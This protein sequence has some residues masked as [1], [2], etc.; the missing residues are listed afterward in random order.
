MKPLKLTLSAFGPYADET[1][2]DFTQLGGQGLFLVTGDTG[3]GKTTIF[4]GI[5][6]ALYG[7]T[8]GGVREASMLR[9][10]YAKPETPTYAEYIFEYKDAVYTVKRSPDYGR[11]KTRGTGMTTQKGEALLT[12]SDGRAPVTKLKE[13]NQTVTDL[14]GLDMKQFTQ[15]A[16]I[17]Q[18]DFRKLLLAD[19]EE[20]SNIFRKLFHT[21]IY[22][23]IQEKLKFEAGGLDKAYKELLRSIR[24][25]TEQVRYSTEDQLGQQWILMEKNGFEG[26][27]EEG[28]E[29]LEQFLKVDKETLKNLNKQIKE[30]DKELEKVN[31][32]LGKAHKEADAKAR[33]EQLLQ[34]KEVLLPQLE[35]AQK[36]AE[37]GAKEP[38]EIQRLMLSIQKEKENLERYTNLENLLRET[39]KASL[40]IEKLGTDGTELQ[41]R[42]KEMNAVLEEKQKEYQTTDGT[43]K[44]KAETDFRKEKIDTLY[45]GIYK[46]CGNLE[47]LQTKISELKIQSGQE[48]QLAYQKKQDEAAE[49]RRRRSCMERPKID[50]VPKGLYI[51]LEEAYVKYFQQ[52]VTFFPDDKDDFMYMLRLLERWEKKSIPAVLA[53]GRP[54][55]AYA[56]AIGLCEHLPLLIFRDDIRDY[57]NEYKL[58]IGKL[59]YASFAAL[60]DS[61]AAWN[62][63]EKR[64]EIFTYIFTHLSRFDDFKRV[65]NNIQMLAPSKKFTGEPV[66]IEREMND[67]E[68][69]AAR[70]A[71]RRRR[72]KERQILEAEKEAKS[73]IPL[74][75]D[76]EQRIFNRRN[77]DWDCYSIWQLMLEE[78]KNIEKLLAVG[79]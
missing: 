64:E 30:N 23:V 2:I 58:R 17:A 28:L 43:E 29:I 61:V 41:N 22:K 49:V 79:E 70:E 75:K 32:L 60:V 6:F 45:A 77:V 67:E 47:F 51:D 21:D 15:I 38:E 57:L 18:G 66:K 63:E 73:L 69:R 68:E 34:E 10:K 19:T 74:N 50:Y 40:Q 3:A 39:E 53:K 46:N 5:T 7:E 44:E 26:N 52:V 16:M 9:S 56:I 4:D 13:V 72:E 8:S 59:I 76:Y 24:Q 11:P 35:Q 14:I 55:A 27:L 62:N 25:Y 48:E 1:V 31:Q 36:A 20:R 33:K 65:Q 54:D 78:N 12:F 37:N 71:E 42:Q